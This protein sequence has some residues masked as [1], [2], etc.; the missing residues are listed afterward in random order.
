ML[1]VVAKQMNYSFFPFIRYG[2]FIGNWI[3]AKAWGIL[4]TEAGKFKSVCFFKPS[5]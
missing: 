2:E 4:N 1:K 3:L 5:W